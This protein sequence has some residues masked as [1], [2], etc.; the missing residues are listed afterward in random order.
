MKDLISSTRRC[1]TQGILSG[2]QRGDGSSLG[3]GIRGGNV[4]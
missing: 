2:N 4:G 1:R 3:Y